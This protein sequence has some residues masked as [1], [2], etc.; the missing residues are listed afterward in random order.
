MQLLSFITES[1]TGW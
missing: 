1:H